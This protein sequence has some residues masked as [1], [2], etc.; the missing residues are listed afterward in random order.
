MTDL[1]F[2]DCE[3]KLPLMSLPVRTT[4][5]RLKTS[6]VMI[7]PGSHLSPQQLQGAGGVT[8]LVAPNLFHCAGL[9]KAQSTFPNA[10]VWGSPGCQ[11]LKPKISW[12][13]QLNPKDWPHSEELPL[14]LIQGMPKVNETV[15]FHRKSK[16]LIVSDLCF[17]LQEASGIGCWIILN[18]F[19]TY[20]QFGVSRLWLKMTKDFPALKK[21][22]L[23]M[24]EWDFENI[25][26]SHGSIVVDGGKDQLKTAFQNRGLDLF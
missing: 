20:Q 7:S 8:D 10:K 21:S 3:V 25:V 23:Q 19:G 24:F 18:L 12:T 9:P 13:S 1:S 22:L 26:M 14:L 11:E 6:L 5:V 17:N 16:T 15:F 4:V 2:L